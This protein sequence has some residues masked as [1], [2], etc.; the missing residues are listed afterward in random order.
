[1]LKLTEEE[2]RKFSHDIASSPDSLTSVIRGH[3]Y[4]EKALRDF[5]TKRLKHPLPSDSNDVFTYRHY[6]HLAMSLGL[7][8]SLLAPLQRLGQIRNRFAHRMDYAIPKEGGI[9]LVTMLAP[10]TRKLADEIWG[11]MRNGHSEPPS[12]P[13]HLI[14]L[15]PRDIFI[16]FTM[17]L[18]LSIHRADQE[19]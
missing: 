9:E 10:E 2:R 17:T 12:I 14:D 18:L 15:P 19:Q 7:Q 8:D 4:I 11:L 6:V 1:M 3:F 5:V 16:V 13:E